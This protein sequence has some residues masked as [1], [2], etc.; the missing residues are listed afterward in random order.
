VGEATLPAVP[1]MQRE[2]RGVNAF[3]PATNIVRNMSYDLFMYSLMRNGNVFISIYMY[4][5]MAAMAPFRDGQ[6]FFFPGERKVKERD[7][8]I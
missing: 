5:V 6:F 1:A 4:K 3:V 7:K 8:S 2:G